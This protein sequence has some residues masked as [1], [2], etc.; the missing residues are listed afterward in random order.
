MSDKV[1]APVAGF[2]SGLSLAID[3]GNRRQLIAILTMSRAFESCLKV[4]ESDGY[5]PELKYRDVFLWI[6]AN[7]FMQCSMAFNQ[8]ILNKSLA[9]FFVTWSQM[10]KNDKVLLG[11]WH[12]MYTDRVPYF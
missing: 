5:V 6:S 12:R 3:S 1:A 10:T 2:A 7:M 8:G 9:K 11:A 4:A